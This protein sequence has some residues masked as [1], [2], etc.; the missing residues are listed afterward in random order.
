MTASPLRVLIASPLEP[1]HVQRIAA[2]DPRIE[3]LHAP[4]LLPTPRYAADH[5]GTARTLTREQR[6]HWQSM[7]AAAQVSYDFD[8]SA[9]AQMPANCPDLRWVQASSS[10]IGE[11]LR[12]TGLDRSDLVFTTAAGIHATPLAEFALTGLLYFVK[13][14][15]ALARWQAAHRWERYTTRQL[16]GMRV[17]VIGLGH[18]GRKVADVLSA[19]GVEVWGVGR[20]APAVRDSLARVTG[21]SALD[22]VLP[23]ADAVVLCCPQT[24]ETEGLMSGARLRLLPEGAIVV[25]IARG[26][27]V[28]EP[29]LIAALADGHLGGACLDVASVEPLPPDSPLWAL[30][31]VLISP[32]SA[33]TVTRENAVLTDLFCDNLRRWLAGEQLLNVY[34]RDKGY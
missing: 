1:E 9:A 16:A 27:V 29:A 8:W 34:S 15:P 2:V 17:L 4:E 28:D 23:A 7:L 19:V 31:N 20:D 26:S 21:V 18:V 13:G 30:P 32:H 25:N 22:D 6:E 11:F 12:R 5:H 3:V 10:G 14:V 33:S 24:P